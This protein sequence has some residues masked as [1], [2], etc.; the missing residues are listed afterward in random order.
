M[1]NFEFNPIDDYIQLRFTCPNCGEENITDEIIIPSPHFEAENHSDSIAENEATHE[2]VCGEQFDINI[3]NGICG[4]DGDISNIDDDSV[5]EV[6]EHCADDDY[7]DEL[8]D[9]E[10][11]P[12]VD[13]NLRD[14]ITAL[15]DMESVN[16]RSK[17]LL[18]RAVCANIIAC[19]EAYLSK[20]YI[21]LVF[22]SQEMKER[23]TKTYKPFQTRKFDLSNVY[24]AFRNHDTVIKKELQEIIY[25]K[26]PIVKA[27]YKALGVDLGD[28]S[29]LCKAVMVRHDI[30]HRNGK[31]KDG[32]IQ[33]IGRTELERLKTVVNDFIKNI[34]RQVNSII[35]SNKAL[36][37]PQ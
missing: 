26:L 36:F 1:A 17:P 8:I 22:S 31:D 32:N 12:Y 11:Y 10:M 29:E 16:E 35:D 19:M 25:H 37:I 20:T 30:V 27:M 33:A 14:T 13:E 18:Y 28:I 7:I 24:E 34:D 21:K 23:F 3:Y 6:I 4:G 15:G 9:E 5:I 2:C